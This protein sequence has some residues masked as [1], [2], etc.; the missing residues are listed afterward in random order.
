MNKRIFR[1]LATSALISSLFLSATASATIVE[2]QTSQ[3]DFQV[4]LYDQTTPKTVENF[5]SYVNKASYSNTVIHRSVSEFI[6]QGG[7]FSVDEESFLQP[8][9]TDPAVINEPIYSNVQATIAMAKLGGDPN[10]AT[11]QFFFNLGDNSANL[12]LQNGGFTAFGEVIGDGMVVVDKIANLGTCVYNNSITD[13]PMH[14]AEELG[15]ANLP[16]PLSDQYVTIYQVTIVDASVNTADDLT[17]TLSI[18][19]DHDGVVNDQ[20]AFP[21]DASEWLD[22]DG[23][24][25]GNNKD[26]DD[27]GDGVLDIN[28]AYPLDPERS[29]APDT[30]DSSG[31]S[32]GLLGLFAL[33]AMRM[34]R[35]IKR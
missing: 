34:R 23:D 5:I 11:S 27:D 14:Q 19:T 30:S 6:I 31:G 16:D 17:P 33:A 32:F 28:D 1:P 20:D 15:C 24:G 2:F 4:N 25:I 35:L 3:G 18:D 29:Q 26:D 21:E 13:I 12:D 7:G 10:S 8:I 9:E 22:T